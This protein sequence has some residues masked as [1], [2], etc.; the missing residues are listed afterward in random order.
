MNMATMKAPPAPL[1]PPDEQFWERYNPHH[2]F[3][4]SGV[5]SLALHVGV[6]VLG[7]L[8]LWWLSKLMISDKTP[9]PVRE[10]MVTSEGNGADGAGTGG[11]EVKPMENVNPLERPMEPSREVPQ[12][13]L[14]NPI[15]QDVLPKVPAGEGL[16]PEDLSAYK[17][18]NE[19]NDDLRKKLLE[20]MNG[21]KGKG[22]GDGASS[23]GVDGPGAS[24]TGAANSSSKR[25][26]RW[27]LNF[28]TENGEDYLRQL[29]AMKAT[30]VIPQPK[31]YKTN[32]AYRDLTSGKGVGEDFDIDKMPGL[33]FVD[34]SPDSAARIAKALGLVNTSPPQFVAF[35]PKEIEEE[36]AAKEKAYRG[37]KESEIFSTKFKIL[38]RDGKPTAVVTDQTP[39]KR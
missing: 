11:G 16:R 5:A 37:R 18:T 15:P 2:E 13:V 24:N 22:P 10:I 12:T 19:L 26:I 25:A 32:K 21:K 36:L 28:K 33:F 3:P 7:I 34:D 23:T 1:A 20:G 17:K 30:L 14:D 38:M 8:G 4:I 9:V 27:E 6:I 29:A 31:D 39:V 35:F